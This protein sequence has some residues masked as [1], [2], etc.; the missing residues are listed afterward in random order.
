[1]AE[2]GNNVTPIR[3][4][5]DNAPAVKGKKKH[6]K[7]P[8]R[9][10]GL[11]PECPVRALG[12]SEGVFFYLD[13]DKQLREL[14]ARHHGRLDLD[15]L[16][17]TKEAGRWLWENFPRTNKE[18]KTN[19]LRYEEISKAMMA[20]AA[21]R[22]IWSPFGRLRGA[23]G[24]RGKNGELVLHCGDKILVCRAD[25]E[26]G[27]LKKDWLDPGVYGSEVYSAA[28]PLPRPADQETAGDAAQ[29]LLEL[30]SAW[31]WRR[32][33]LDAALLLGWLGCAL[34]GGALTWRP[35][36]WITGA[37]GMGKSTLLDH[38]LTPIFDGA[39]IAVADTTEA[40]LRQAVAYS[41]LA[42]VV[43]E[44]EPE[45]DWRK[46]AQVMKLARMA[47]SGAIVLRGGEAHKS[48]QF[49]LRNCFAFQSVLVPSMSV[50]D[51]SRLAILEL[52][53][54]EGPP[55]KLDASRILQIGRVLR[56]RLVD[57]WPRLDATIARYRDELMARVEGTDP[58]SARQADVFGT[59]LGVA[60][61]LMYDDPAERN[62]EAREWVDGIR[63]LEI[64]DDERVSDED[65]L[66]DHIMTAVYDPYRSGSA[67]RISEWVHR[68]AGKRD[69]EVKPAR[70]M[71]SNL[72]IYVGPYR[73][74]PGQAFIGATDG[75]PVLFIGFA[76]GSRGITELL[77]DTHWSGRP[78]QTPPWVQAIKRFA[79]KTNGVEKSRQIKVGGFPH[80]C[81]LLV[82]DKVLPD[83][84]SEDAAPLPAPKISNQDQGQGQ[85]G[86]L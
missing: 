74:Q 77:K 86:A 10:D 83:D 68:A 7:E 19:G 23:G 60:E 75:K 13:P 62:A 81:T 48:T 22:G 47:A 57:A 21:T 2:D 37:P 38:I 1:M 85:G 9:D 40:G 73:M 80:R 46:V 84:P 31:P 45:A 65:Q 30:L 55:P 17:C 64:S 50:A 33:R 42:A 28:S 61:L 44:L 32:G 12:H 78:G 14:Q 15:A 71:L 8:P 66:F 54:I 51:R 26:T 34:L 5:I 53:R 6:S 70:T 18:G 3:L 41:T 82:L 39:M 36:I 69:Y 56:R 20:A 24:W 67:A 16:F 52:G 29:E 25:P 59:L 49:H 76:H 4:A 79:D 27:D 35:V 11:P 72:G 43:D 63:L 58:A